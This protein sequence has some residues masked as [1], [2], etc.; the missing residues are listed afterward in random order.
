[1][2]S[3]VRLSDVA[4]RAEVGVGTVSRVLNGSAKVSAITRQKV[5]DA[6]AELG[7]VPNL[8]ARSLAANRTGLIAAIIPVLG[9]T[10][11]FEIIQSM[12]DVLHPYRMNLMIGACGY[13]D[14]VKLHVIKAF[15][16][17]RPDAIYVTGVRH[18]EAVR[19]ALERSGIPVVEGS[20][21]TDDPIDTVVGYSNFNASVDLTRLLIDRGFRRIWHVTASKDL[22]GRID[23]RL[24]GFQ[25]VTSAEAGLEVDVI[26]CENSFDGGAEAVRLIMASGVK[27]EALTFATDVMAVGGLLECQRRGIAVPERLAIAGFG[28]LTIARSINPPLTTV[29]V[30]R[31]GLGRKAAEIIVS[32]LQ[33]N[34]HSSRIVDVGFEVVERESTRRGRRPVLLA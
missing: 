2:G 29:K 12:S 23:D 11:H 18:T 9:Y 22:N 21:L 5:V 24:A 32:R 33:G 4:K 16:A 7:Y 6:I 13:S 17:R 8:V 19:T 26:R 30:D 15:L 10:Q 3:T 28:D 14:E 34:D 25:W 31:V 1:M 27:V 20:N